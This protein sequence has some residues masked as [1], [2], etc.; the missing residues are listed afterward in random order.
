MSDEL[1]AL[2]AIGEADALIDAGGAAWIFKHSATC[3]ISAR[4]LEAFRAYRAE[5][6]SIPAGLVVVQSAREVS[7]HIAQRTGVRHE[8]P[9]VLLVRGGRVLFHTSHMKITVR[10]LSGAAASISSQ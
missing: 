4:A 6:G 7:N 10:A 3:P 2:T 9:Q 1:Q 8:S 5:D